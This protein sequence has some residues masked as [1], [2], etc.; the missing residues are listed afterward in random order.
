MCNVKLQQKNIS[1]SVPQQSSG[2]T[3]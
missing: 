3:E 2:A 1:H